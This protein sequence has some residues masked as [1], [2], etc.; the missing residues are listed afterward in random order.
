[1]T[2]PVRLPMIVVLVLSS[3]CVV[4]FP[5]TARTQNPITAA[6]DAFRRAQEE[7][8]RK[9]EE[10]A[11]RRQGQ[12]VPAAPATAPPAQAGQGGAPSVQP[13]GQVP[14]TLH[15]PQETARLAAAA[16]FMDV[17]GLKL[18]APV[19][20][21]ESLFKSLNSKFKFRPQVE[22]IWPAD[23]A[24]I[25]KQPPPTAPK[26]LRYVAAEV[27][28]GSYTEAWGVQFAEHPNP[29][30]VV[31]IKRTISYAQG[32]G[33]ALDGLLE[34]VRKKYGPESATNASLMIPNSSQRAFVGRWYFDERGQALRGN[35]GN[36]L[37][38]SCQGVG[39]QIPQGN[40]GLC[41]TLTILNV[42]AQATGN[43][44]VHT[45]MVDV[46]NHPLEYGAQET[47]KAYLRQVEEERAAQ[48]QKGASQRPAPK[49]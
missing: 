49:L 45:L 16:S 20:G 35:V 3:I 6:R 37:Y 7:A 46:T 48:Q 28:D 8:K 27:Q 41:G 34:A 9:Q 24:G 31:T 1:M 25:E 29:A 13:S 43:G 12:S 44:V 38:G 22:I 18:G 2:Q 26:S 19:A 42:N 47:T 11:R 21:V 4:A 10:D 17:A 23:R 30:V 36:Q 14:V 39:M 32:T 5:T 33:P 15:S 40:P